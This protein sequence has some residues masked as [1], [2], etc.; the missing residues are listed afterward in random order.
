MRGNAIA[1]QSRAKLGS[2]SDTGQWGRTSL[3]PVAEVSEVTLPS[4]RPSPTLLVMRF[5]RAHLAIALGSAG[6]LVLVFLGYV[7]WL[8]NQP[9]VLSRS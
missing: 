5:S 4:P 8:S 1:R 7:Y 9:P 6:L 3:S 2:E